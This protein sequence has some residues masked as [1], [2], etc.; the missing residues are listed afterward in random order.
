M[1]DNGTHSFNKYEASSVTHPQYTDAISSDAMELICTV[2]DKKLG[3]SL[4]TRLATPML[5]QE[6]NCSLHSGVMGAEIKGW[7]D[8]L[9][10]FTIIH[11]YTM[12][13]PEH[14]CILIHKQ[15]KPWSGK[16][17]VVVVH[18]TSTRRKMKL[19]NT[20]TAIPQ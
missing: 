12:I 16:K 17:K 20:I 10:R 14:L 2:C 6:Q 5:L 7:R 19:L 4:G 1:Y 9:N 15:I 11:I 13:M 18:K 3:R 8:R